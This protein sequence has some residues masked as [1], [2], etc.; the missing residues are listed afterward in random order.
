MFVIINLAYGYTVA[1]L[2][3]VLVLFVV[4]SRQRSILARRRRDAEIGRWGEVEV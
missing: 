4:F 2:V 3:G 1:G